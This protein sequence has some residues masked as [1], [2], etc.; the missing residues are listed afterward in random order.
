MDGLQFHTLDQTHTLYK[1]VKPLWNFTFLDQF[2]FDT[3]FWKSEFIETTRRTESSCHDFENPYFCQQTQIFDT[4]NKHVEWVG[5]FFSLFLF[6][7]CL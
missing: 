2:E 1:K 5:V 4:E 7:F 6:S 3:F